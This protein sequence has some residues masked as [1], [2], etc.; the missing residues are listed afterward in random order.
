MVGLL[1]NDKLIKS[2]E[3]GGSGKIQ[4]LSQQ[5]MGV[6]PEDGHK[7]ETCSGY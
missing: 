5:V 7:T 1:M 3:I 6:P 2:V 4:M